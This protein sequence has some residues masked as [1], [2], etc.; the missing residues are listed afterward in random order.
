LQPSRHWCFLA[1]IEENATFIRPEVRVRDRDGALVK[2][3]F[4]HDN[5][6]LDWA[7][8]RPTPEYLQPG[9]T[10]AL[11]YAERKM[12]MD[13]TQGIRVEDLPHCFVFRAPLSDVQQYS[14]R[15]LALADAS[16]PAS[17]S[18]STCFACTSSGAV[19]E[20]QGPS[21]SAC[22]SCELAQYCGVACQ[23]ADWRTHKKL[24]KDSERLLRL[25]LLPRHP[26][27]RRVNMKDL[28]PAPLAGVRPS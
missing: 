17:T 8:F 21:L 20:G 5:G 14:S 12:F 23:K 26:Y 10:L 27:G 9:W 18:K 11:G 2:V 19:A 25:S 4:Y 3:M 28:P 13:M 6:D 24:C 7:G 22:G 15:L 16:A 1:Q